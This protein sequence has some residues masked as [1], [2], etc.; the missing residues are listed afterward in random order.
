MATANRAEYLTIGSVPMQTAAWDL[1]N[2]WE[3][4]N[5]AD[6]RGSNDQTPYRRGRRGRRHLEDSKRVTL[7]FAIYGSHDSGGNPATAGTEREQLEA[8]IDELKVALRPRQNA[9]DGAADG[10]LVTP[11]KTLTGRIQ[12]KSGLS[13]GPLG[14]AGA[15]ATADIEILD[16]V[17]YDVAGQ[18]DVTETGVAAGGSEDMTVPNPGSADQYAMTIELTGTATSVRLTSLTWD[19]DGDTW[20]E[21]G[22]ALEESAVGTTID[23]DTFSAVRNSLSVIGL[24]TQSGHERWLPLLAGVDNTIRVEPVGGTATVQIVHNPAYG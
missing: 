6:I 14:P 18:V 16:G 10:S 3:L 7:Q 12:A 15:R 4:W 9:S 17:L 19:P 21:F 8:N 22:G 1:I 23:T 5:A 13:L 2:L 11:S 24:M 20:I